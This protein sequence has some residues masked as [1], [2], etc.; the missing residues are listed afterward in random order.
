MD[1]DAEVNG[2]A[3]NRGKTESGM[4]DYEWFVREGPRKRF[5][6]PRVLYLL[7][8]GP[9]HGYRIIDAIG[10]LPFPGP[11]PDSA[12]VYRALRELEQSGFIRSRWEGGEK[13]PAK[14]VYTITPAGRKRLSLWVDSF[15]ER[16]KLLEAFIRLCEKR[17]T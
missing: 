3:S 6:E 7:T 17:K 15:K 11:K 8:L 9:A 2:L 4:G 5:I 14:R 13:G 10:N 1:S 16:V 12:A